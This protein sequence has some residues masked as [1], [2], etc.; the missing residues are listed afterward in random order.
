HDRNQGSFTYTRHRLVSLKENIAGEI[1]SLGG[2]LGLS[3]L[4]EG[5]DRQLEGLD[6]APPPSP[7][8]SP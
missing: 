4:I 2:H 8:F 6:V 7:S 5:L 3:R 1:D